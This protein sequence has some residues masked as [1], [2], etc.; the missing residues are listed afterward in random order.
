MRKLFPGLG[1]SLSKCEKYRKA[2]IDAA[3]ELNTDA[4]PR[5]ALRLLPDLQNGASLGPLAIQTIPIHS[6]QYGAFSYRA[7]LEAAAKDE[8]E[9]RPERRGRGP[10][11]AAASRFL[12]SLSLSSLL[13]FIP[14]LEPQPFPTPPPT[15]LASSPCRLW[16]DLKTT[17]PTPFWGVG[18]LTDL[19]P[20]LLLLLSNSF[21]LRRPLRRERR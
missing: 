11:R 14:S 17:V 3:V 15:P 8:R 5:S 10:P 12:P 21:P 18:R 19:S 16:I 9:I 20:R 4:S 2:Q 13:T 7:T 1:Y 6:G